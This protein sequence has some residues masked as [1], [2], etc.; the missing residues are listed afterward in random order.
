MLAAYSAGIAIIVW[1]VLVPLSLARIVR[2]RASAVDLRQHLGV[3][4]EPAALNRPAGRQRI[5]VHAVSTGEMMAARALVKELPFLAPHCAVLLTTANPETRDAIRRDRA[6]FRQVEDCVLLPWDRASAMRHWLRCLRPDALVIVETE[7][8]PNLYRACRAL[9]IPLFVV[10]G[11][12]YARDVSRYALARWLFRRV[13]DC[14]CWIG[15]QDEDE[16]ERFRRIG[17]RDER[18]EVVGNLKFDA[19]ATTRNESRSRRI[20]FDTSGPTVIGG[21]THAPEESWLLEAL[22]RLRPAFPSLRLILA[23]RQITRAAAIGRLA[24]R[25]GFEV[26]VWSTRRTRMTTWDV[27]V[28]DELGWLSALYACADVAVLGGSFSP[29]GGQNVIEPAAR[30]RPVLVGPFVEHV[31]GLVHDLERAGAIAWIKD[32][33]ELPSR[34][35][36]ELRRLLAMPAERAAMGA[37][38]RLYCEGRRGVARTYARVIT[39]TLERCHVTQRSNGESGF[40]PR[41]S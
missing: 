23:P 3:A 28:V 29:R 41:P 18:I 19:S 13:L 27:L 8:W 16:R 30:G 22:R 21:S 36:A 31:A 6:D 4:G 7:I 24:E 34:L 1:T 37:R 5:I 26:V 11:R 32:S 14:A 39:D 2:G 38:G 9:Q 25:K 40:I 15:V 17:A 12:V 20:A 35:E 33:R 10:S